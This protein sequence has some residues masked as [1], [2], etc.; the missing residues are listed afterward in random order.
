MGE[1]QKT[2]YRTL[3]FKSRGR[4]VPITLIMSGMD[5][6]EV[7]ENYNT[8]SG[9][10]RSSDLTRIPDF[11]PLKEDEVKKNIREHLERNL[12]YECRT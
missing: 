4:M 8:L 5:A 6:A 1:R 7:L 12:A 10:R 9:F 11:T 2:Y 3:G